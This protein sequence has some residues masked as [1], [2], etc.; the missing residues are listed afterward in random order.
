MKS[1]GSF[2]FNTTAL[3]VSPYKITDKIAFYVFSGSALFLKI[4]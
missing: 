1:T 2:L 3:N 4:K